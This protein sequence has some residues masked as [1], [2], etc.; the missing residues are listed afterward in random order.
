[1][2]QDSS[3]VLVRDVVKYMV[4][5]IV[6]RWDSYIENG[7]MSTT[8]WQWVNQKSRQESSLEQI[9]RVFD[10]NSRIIFVSSP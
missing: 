7:F 6:E 3:W 2:E 5:M 8:L 10:D 1:M 9:I 4:K